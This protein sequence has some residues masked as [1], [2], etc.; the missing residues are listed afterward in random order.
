MGLSS[1]QRNAAY[2]LLG[3]CQDVL[4]LFPGIFFNGLALL[5]GCVQI[6]V[7]CRL[8]RLEHAADLQGGFGNGT[9]GF[10][11]QLP[12]LQLLLQLIDTLLQAVRPLRLRHQQLQKLIAV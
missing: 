7:S 6:Q 4:G 2:F 3:L 1:F 11:L 12:G 10:H 9:H 5:S 8:H